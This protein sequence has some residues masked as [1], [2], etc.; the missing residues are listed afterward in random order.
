MKCKNIVHSVNKSSNIENIN[1]YKLLGH[2][3][4][5]MQDKFSIFLLIILV[6]VKVKCSGEK[7]CFLL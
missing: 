3:L 5:K 1:L 2:I 4:V 6:S 7:I